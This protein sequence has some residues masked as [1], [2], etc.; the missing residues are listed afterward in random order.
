[1]LYY[2]LRWCFSHLFPNCCGMNGNGDGNEG[3]Q[4]NDIYVYPATD[5]TDGIVLQYGG[6]LRPELVYGSGSPPMRRR[7][8]K[9]REVDE[10]APESTGKEK[11]AC[12]SIC[13]ETMWPDVK[14]RTLRCDHACCSTCLRKWLAVS[15]K[16]PSK[17]PFVMFS[18]YFMDV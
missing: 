7:G 2:V 17:L 18:L 15:T 16:C 5:G 8:L 14:I 6:I 13:L 12:C 9:K 10:C 4:S 11:D 1:M 3:R